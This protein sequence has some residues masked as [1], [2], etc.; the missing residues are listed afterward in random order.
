[1]RILRKMYSEK[2]FYGTIC[3]LYK[4]NTFSIV[5]HGW[6]IELLKSYIAD[7]HIFLSIMKG[8]IP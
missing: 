3:T 4:L 1:M 6:K 2:I 7:L 8:H 5:L